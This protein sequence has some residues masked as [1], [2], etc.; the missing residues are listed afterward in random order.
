MNNFNQLMSKNLISKEILEFISENME[1]FDPIN[2]STIT[3]INSIEN[4]LNNC[5]FFI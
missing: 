4:F 2:F 3:D 1:N 5:R